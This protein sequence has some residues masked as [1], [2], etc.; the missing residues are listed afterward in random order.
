MQR[1]D[2]LAR[3]AIVCVFQLVFV[4]FSSALSH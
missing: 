2:W 3:L 4:H 1:S